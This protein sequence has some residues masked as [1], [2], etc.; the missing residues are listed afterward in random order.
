MG[1]VLVPPDQK[2]VAVKIVD[3]PNESD[4]GPFPVPDNAPIED[5]PLAVNEDRGRCRSRARRSTTSSATAR[6][7]AT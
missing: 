3:Y 6:A 7:T 1:F 2:R 4:P 5:W